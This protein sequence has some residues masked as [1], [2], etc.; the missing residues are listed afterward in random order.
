MLASEAL[1]IYTVTIIN[2]YVNQRVITPGLVV[3]MASV[4]RI[5]E[6]PLLLCF[7]L[8]CHLQMNH[9]Y[10]QPQYASFTLLKKIK[11]RYAIKN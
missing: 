6:Q 2:L 1:W 11:C 8:H 10:H 3:L 4:P 5:V 7:H 9:L